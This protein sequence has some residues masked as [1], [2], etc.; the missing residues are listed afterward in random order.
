MMPE[1]TFLAGPLWLVT[2]LH[3]VTLT[4]HFLAMNFVVGGIIIVLW[5]K[6]GDHFNDPT[7][8]RVIDLFPSAMAL[9][10]T[11]G[12]APLLFV[13]LVYSQQVYTAAI[14]SGWFWMGIVAAVIFSY[15]FLYAAAFSKAAG[16]GRQGWYL[17]L[18]LIGLLYVAYTY[19]SVFSLAEHPQVHAPLY[20]VAPAGTA[21]NPGFGDYIVRWLHMLFGAV[22]VGGFFVGLLG[23]D[24][25][26]AFG[27]GKRIFLY[28]TII[29]ALVG[30]VYLFLLSEALLPFMRTAGIWF[31]TLG[32]AAAFG[33]LHFYF[34]K[35]F[36]W[37]GLVLTVAVA[38]MVT[39]RH[40]VRLVRLEPYFDPAT[41]PVQPQ[42]SAFVVFLI[43]FVVAVSVL[44][45]MLRLFF[46]K[47]GVAAG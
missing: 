32:V 18:A 44:W 28:G 20:M 11:L 12:V 2:V 5:G 26:S 37:S 14:L 13:Q 4:L 17:T 8:R 31:L 43:F 24:N 7:V 29:N 34:Q 9:V 16:A 39:A 41:I 15:Y 25:P 40:Y 22:T 10:V 46:S 35:R 42:W 27:I 21:L 19:S 33:T 47:K 36:V 30:L 3:I 23:R 1:Y 38:L 6:F 45:Y